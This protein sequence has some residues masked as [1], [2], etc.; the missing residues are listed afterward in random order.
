MKKT[1]KQTKCMNRHKERHVC[2]NRQDIDIETDRQKGNQVDKCMSRQRY[3][4]DKHTG[5]INKQ[6]L[7]SMTYIQN[8]ARQVYLQA[9]TK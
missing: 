4:M 2:V 9:E 5:K 8:K 7:V 3:K 6:T 1:D